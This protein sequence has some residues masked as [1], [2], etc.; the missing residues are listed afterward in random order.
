MSAPPV[1]LDIFN[2]ANFG[3]LT[4]NANKANYPV[5][6]GMLVLPN[7][8]TWGDGTYQNSASGTG[9]GVTNPMTSN[10]DG[11][12]FSITN[13]DTF[14]GLFVNVDELNNNGGTGRIDILSPVNHQ[15]N[16]IQDV[17]I[18][19]AD[20]FYTA[21]LGAILPV[22]SP[23]GPLYVD[24]NTRRV[25]I[26]VPTPQEDFEVDGNI[27]LDSAGTN[28]IKFYNGPS[29]LERSE[30]DSNT[31][32]TNGGNLIIYT[33]EDGG[34]ITAR[35]TI[36]EDGRVIITNRI[37]GLPNPVAGTDAANKQY[38]DS[39]LVGYVQN[40]MTGDLN[41]GGFK[42]TNLLDPT[43]AQEAATKSYV[44]SAI[45]PVIFVPAN[46]KWMNTGN[47]GITAPAPSQ[48]YTA[49]NMTVA[50]INDG[51]TLTSASGQVAVPS[52]GIYRVRFSCNIASAGNGEFNAKAQ[53]IHVAS[54]VIF[55]GVCCE[56]V[57]MKK[58]SNTLAQGA[59]IVCEGMVEMLAG[60]YIYPQIYY[61]S[62]PPGVTPVI[63]LNYKGN[64]NSSLTNDGTELLMQKI[65]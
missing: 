43:T 5:L 9:G 47:T 29:G 4:N 39:S 3:Q 57:Y 50:P 12:G 42:I 38:V 46:L 10:L 28:R 31:S 49:D 59:N 44:D 13:V 45:P 11:G 48:W 32:G 41:A 54:G 64:F 22:G 23:N 15:G 8:V 27:Q 6:Q 2:S 53:I 14:S 17:G 25:G 1:N 18:I 58:F 37:E 19:G 30:I 21:V 16:D 56:S 62:E 63:G 7:G 52:T 26:N 60:D 61:T 55:N 20:G 40:P 65:G 34:V 24:T 35:M 51:Y 33:K 36:E